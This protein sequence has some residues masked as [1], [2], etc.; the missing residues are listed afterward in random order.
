MVPA[1]FE[2]RVYTVVRQIPR[3]KVTTYGQI[4]YMI[5]FPKNARLVGATLK[6]SKRDQITP[7]HRIVNA[8]GRLVPGWEEQRELLLS[9]GVKFKE[10]GH[11]KMKDHFWQ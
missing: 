8:A 5:G 6:H 10:N 7:C 2:E 3:G 4:A 11:V 9:E 1:D